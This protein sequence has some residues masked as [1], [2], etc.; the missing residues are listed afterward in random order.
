MSKKYAILAVLA[1]FMMYSFPNNPPNGVTGAP[2]E[3]TCN[4]CHSLGSGMQN[5]SISVTGMPATITPNTAYVLTMTS[6][7]PNG[8]AELAG[9]Q[10]TI[11]NS[12]NQQAGLITGASSGSHTEN[13]GG[14]QYWEH[15][16]AQPYPMSNV[17]MWTATWTSP[18]MP[19]NT[20][21][22]YYAAGN[23]ANGNGFSTGD[24]IVTTSGS[25][26][27]M[28]GGSDLAVSI[29]NYNDVLCFGQN[30]GSATASVEGG[31]PP[32]T[33]SWSNGS[34][35]ATINNL[36]AGVYTV[37]VTDDADATGTA[38]IEISEPDEIE[39]N[40]P[41]IT[42]VTCN[43]DNDG[44]I[45]VG[46]FGG[47]SPYTYTWSNGGN[48]NTISGL[49]AGSYT[50][51]VTDDNTCTETATYT[52]NQPPAI[53]IS[54]NNLEHESCDGE[55]DGIIS[56]SVSGGESPYF[57][58]WSNGSIGMT[59]SNLSP[60][61][62]NVTVTDNN[63][64][65]ET[66][67]YT[68]NPGGSTEVNLVSIQ[69]VTCFGGNNGSISIIATGGV[70]PYTYN[71]SNGAT[72][73]MITGLVAGNYLVTVSD[74]ND[75]EVVEGYT[76]NQP[77]AITIAITQT[78]P[79][80][81]FGDATADLTATVAG[82]TAPYNALWS[83]GTVGLINSD[84]AAG[85]YTIT[86]TDA[87]TCTSS[88]TFTVTQPMQ[89]TLTV[90]TTDETSSG[91]NDGTATANVAGGTPGY[92]YIWSNG[93]TTAT[94]TGLAPG[95]Y[96]VTV[97]DAASCSAMGTGQVDAFGCTLLVSIGSDVMICEDETVV[98][99]S[100]VT[101]ATGAVTY[102]WT[103]GTTA[104]SLEINA[105]GEYCVTV[106]DEAGCQS[107]DCVMITEIIIPAFDCP[108]TNESAPGANDGAI[109]CDA[110]PF[111]SYLWSNGAMTSTISGLS[112]GEYCVTVSDLTGC[113]RAQCF[114]V[115]SGDCQM[116]VT[117]TQ[118]NV[119]CAGNATGTIALTVTGGTHPINFIWSDGDTTSSVG[120][121][122]AGNYSVTVSDA[123]GCVEILSFTITEPPA[124]TITLDSVVVEQI[125]SGTIFITVS[126]GVPPYQYAWG[127][128]GGS[129]SMG[130]DTFF[131][132]EQGIHSVCVAD[133]AGCTTCL[134]SIPVDLGVGLGPLLQYRPLTIYPVPADDRLTISL[135][136]PVK[137]VLIN[138]IDGRVYNLIKAPAGNI[139]DVSSLE[140]GWYILRIYDGER[141]YVARLVK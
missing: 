23:I 74:A 17:V 28:G 130:I 112:P 92:T 30:N 44:S 138:G 125:G 31:V 29:T 126:G 70:A 65:T 101:G 133:N 19:P 137:E 62:Y 79:N 38:S 131:T 81:C 108:V 39:F 56:I 69:H 97:S 25:G 102:S 4:N 24:L 94:I 139:L 106:S 13:S 33:Y 134:D 93:G 77:G 54:L 8:L 41:S 66:E 128:P 111:I 103:G 75:C 55:E 68:I 67:S 122:M 136:I 73:A 100:T 84:L 113:T 63:N 64:C 26:M 60:G 36:F 85:M 114:N 116:I 48:G 35:S 76:I 95:T 34:T 123:A 89:L 10:L 118:S 141:W 83:D 9:F 61:T 87:S 105:G 16:P 50:V 5:G 110:T 7:N 20:T 12:N 57:A 80:L 59:I 1:G 127:L 45:S 14:R 58:E 49:T 104:D 11:L 40:S 135:D 47:I 51:T 53:N 90:T 72:G 6:N 22:T 98:I 99:H 121:L 117:G 78:S 71:W 86:V 132:T 119:D 21:I 107:V 18:N 88:Q 43:G 82:G 2:G 109:S 129:I 42:H 52:V 46:V 115:Q 27:L 96:S 32:Y 3:G 124:I 15:F 140:P 120:N 37:T 91:A